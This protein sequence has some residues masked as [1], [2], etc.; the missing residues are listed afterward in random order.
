MLVERAIK[1][2]GYEKVLELT[3]ES[4]KKFVRY[5]EKQ[6]YVRPHAMVLH[7]HHTTPLLYHGTT[8][9][10][11]SGGVSDAVRARCTRGAGTGVVL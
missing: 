4:K 6:R 2:F 8:A 10:V 11:C 1:R 9:R 3:P 7:R 5:V